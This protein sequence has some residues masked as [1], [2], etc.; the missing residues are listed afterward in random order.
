MSFCCCSRHGRSLNSP[1]EALDLES[2]ALFRKEGRGLALYAHSAN[3][4]PV[5]WGD[6]ISHPSGF[7]MRALEAGAVVRA[8]YAAANVD[9]SGEQ[10]CIAVPGGSK[11]V[12]PIAVVL[13]GAHAN[14]NDIDDDECEL[15]SEFADRASTGYLFVEVTRLRRETSELR[16][17]LAAL[18]LST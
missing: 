5:A 7:G 9:A 6:P 18:E 3:F 8:P 2:A 1:V 17:R 13:Y 16:D 10:P 15:L 4:D 11:P 14:G 12:G